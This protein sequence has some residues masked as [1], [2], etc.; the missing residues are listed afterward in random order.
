MPGSFLCCYISL[1]YDLIFI[2]IY[3]SEAIDSTAPRRPQ[4]FVQKTYCSQM[5][6]APDLV[7]D[8]NREGLYLGSI[9]Y[10]YVCGLVP[11][12]NKQNHNKKMMRKMIKAFLVKRM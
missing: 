5:W 8:I 3:R 10:I 9:G 1:K 6:L 7:C 4:V 11:M 12:L 2:Y